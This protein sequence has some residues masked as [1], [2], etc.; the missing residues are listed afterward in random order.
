MEKEQTSP[1]DRNGIVGRK[2]GDKER[3]SM[4]AM[5][6]PRSVRWRVC[7]RVL[8]ESEDAWTSE[9]A[10]WRSMYRT[11]ASKYLCDPR[12]RDNQVSTVN[13][14]LSQNPESNWNQYWKFAELQQDIKQDIVRLHPGEKFFECE[15][16]RSSLTNVLLIWSQIHSDLGYRQGMHEILGNVYFVVYGDA[17][18]SEDADGMPPSDVLERFDGVTEMS[19]ETTAS[20]TDLRYVEHDAYALFSAIMGAGP[21][22]KSDYAPH[23]FQTLKVRRLRTYYESPSNDEPRRRTREPRNRP[24]GAVSTKAAPIIEACKRMMQALQRADPVVYQHLQKHQVEPQ[25]FSIKW[26][27]LL[28]GREMSIHE[29][30]ALWDIFFE[31]E[32]RSA[33]TDHTPHIPWD[34]CGFMVEGFAV[35]M[36]LSMRDRLLEAEDNS[37]CLQHLMYFSTITDMEDVLEKTKALVSILSSLPTQEDPVVPQRIRNTLSMSR[38]DDDGFVMVSHSQKHDHLAKPTAG[39][40]TA[41]KSAGAVDTCSASSSPKA[42]G[43]PMASAKEKLQQLVA[44]LEMAMSNT[45][46]AMIDLRDLDTLHGVLRE[47][48]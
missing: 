30:F 8:G 40:A 37:A 11:K 28:F 36:I 6:A 34:G 22:D 32:F 38:C 25:L 15:R 26:F 5:D 43:Q 23:E 10:S 12:Y 39:A 31:N 42:T 44:R 27:R 2:D 14:P 1:I 47:M 4:D 3:R 18:K 7:L 48:T 41:R 35:A 21:S 13:N 29:L 24:K 46:T 20:P 45:G 9:C 33:A 17:A 16:V 19:V